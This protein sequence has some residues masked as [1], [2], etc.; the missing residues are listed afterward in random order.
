MQNTQNQQSSSDYQVVEIT[1]VIHSDDLFAITDGADVAASGAR[2]A[3]MLQASYQQEF[4]GAAVSV[5]VG[6][7]EAH[8]LH[9]I[10]REEMADP[11]YGNETDVGDDDLHPAVR[12]AKYLAEKLYESG[13][14]L[15]E[16]S[17]ERDVTVNGRTFA[18]RASR[19]DHGYAP[20]ATDEQGQSVYLGGEDDEDDA[21]PAEALARGE[22]YLR[23]QAERGNL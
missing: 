20:E 23:E 16:A 9:L 1:E 19:Y 11:R 8:P 22:R 3:E 13:A 18:L 17:T 10:I 7:Q 21:T 4:P 12:T 2:Y 14:W 15:V 6:G 5:R